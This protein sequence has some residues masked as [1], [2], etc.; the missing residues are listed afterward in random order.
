MPSQS[1]I[2]V[3]LIGVFG[4]IAAFAV[5]HA[6]SAWRRRRRSMRPQREPASAVR[7]LLGYGL[8][9]GLV[10]GG[11]RA[12]YALVPHEVAVHTGRLVGEGLF[13][14]ANVPGYMAEF[15]STAAQVTQG[16]PLVVFYRNPSPAEADEAALQRAI[17][18][19]KLR[20]EQLREAGVDALVL[21]QYESVSRRLDLL[22]D[23]ERQLVRQR[24]LALLDSKEDL[25]ALQDDLR[26]AERA[27]SAARFRLEEDSTELRSATRAQEAIGAVTQRGVLSALERDRITER[28]EQA[29]NAVREQRERIEQLQG[30]VVRISARLADT[31]TPSQNPIVLK[32]EDW[33]ED[34]AAEK[35][36]TLQE[37]YQVKGRLETERSRAEAR[38]GAALAQLQLEI[39]A[40]EHILDAFRRGYTATTPITVPAPWDALVGY[41]APSPA[42]AVEPGAPIISIH[43][44][45]QL[46]AEVILH[47]RQARR[48]GDDLRVL[49]RDDALMVAAPS[50]TGVISA[51]EQLSPTETRLRVVGNP[52][53]RLIRRLV[54]GEQIALRLVFESRGLQLAAIGERLAAAGQFLAGQVRR[55][56]QG[57]QA[58]PGPAPLV[59]NASAHTILLTLVGAAALIVVLLFLLRRRRQRAPPRA[60]PG[61]ARAHGP[62]TPERG[63]ASAALAGQAAGART[64][65]RPALVNP[66][67][68]QV[69]PSAAEAPAA[70]G[71]APAADVVT[72]AAAAGGRRGR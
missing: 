36:A 39:D 47:P 17:L 3:L 41:R 24:E 35:Q 62:A 56:G 1:T 32:L 52:P 21:S 30:E 40:A 44:P 9:V 10:I 68:R 71:R 43:R 59:A 5:S 20:S 66:Y 7:V 25:L 23:R 54:Q 49:M 13:T 55:V 63:V 4:G 67:I 61:A 2:V 19:E 65:E 16:E 12:F 29:Q 53:P 28:F 15:P 69:P 18:S 26:Q 33:L 22:N 70:P 31:E 57:L 72:P 45:G 8:V 51:R 64:P 14:V 6:L 11:I 27:L 42:N 34:L 37:Y 38:R 50:F 58:T 60:R 48:L 46:W